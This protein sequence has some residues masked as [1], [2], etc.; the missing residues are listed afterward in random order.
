MANTAPSTRRRSRQAASPSVPFHEVIVVG[1]GFAGIGAAI[2]LCEA[3]I[4]DFVLLE[5][6]AEIGGVWRENTYPGCACD[7]P[8]SLYSYSFAPNPGWSRVFAGQA[9]IKDYLQSTAQR[10]GVM[11]HVRLHH[12]VLESAW[13]DVEKLWV[14]NT[15]AGEYRARFVI[16]ACGPMHEPVYPRI[17]G[18]KEFAGTIFHSARWNH[19]YDLAGKR[20]A[21]IGTGASAIQFVPAIQPRVGKLT[22]FQRTPQWILPKMDQALP[23]LVQG[24]FKNLPLTQLALRGAV[25]GI[26]ETLNGGMHHPRVMQQFQRLARFNIHR[27]VKD[28]AMRKKLTPD[29]IIG[30]KRVLQSNDWYPALV[31][32]NVDVVAAGVREI[33]AHSILDENGREHEVDAIVLGTGFEVTAPPIAE[34]VRGRSGRTMAEVW[35]GSPEGYMGTM[36]AGCPNGF[37]MFGPNLAV[38]SSAILIIEAQLAY[39]VDALKK[40]REQGILTIDVDPVRQAAFNQKVQA[41]LQDT[42]WNKG[43]CTSYFIDANGRNSTLWPWTTLEMRKQLSAF[44][45]EE[46]VVS[47]AG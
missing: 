18:I 4:T 10:F 24:L 44:P 35:A 47:R 17:P 37:L 40:A 21:V 41:A 23:P 25:Y 5:K 20:V 42:V 15:S 32:P 13:D 45:L 12:E 1:G 14:L 30:C 43:G 31:Q 26:F 19:D 36:V 2:K 38:S 7:V 9:E 46:Y 8:S 3:G 34:R 16:M 33:R 27:T 6:A 22:V 28:P 11:P 39:I 29:Y